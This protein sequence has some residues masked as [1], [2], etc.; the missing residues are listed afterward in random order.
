MCYDTHVYNA[1][2]LR[3]LLYFRR[4]ERV[5]C[6]YVVVLKTALSV[7]RVYVCVCV[8][9]ERERESGVEETSSRER[10]DD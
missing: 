2:V 9:V 10:E 6:M 8:C 4:V 5:V 1:V 7:L 3:G